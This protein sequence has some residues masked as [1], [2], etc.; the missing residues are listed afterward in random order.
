VPEKIDG[1]GVVELRID[2]LLLLPGTYDLSGS[3]YDFTCQHP[4]DHRH[5]ALRFDVELGDP[6]EEHGFL[7]LGGS[8]SADWSAGPAGA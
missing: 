4:Y 5:R 1:T 6:R 2:R 7:S 8:W 3:V